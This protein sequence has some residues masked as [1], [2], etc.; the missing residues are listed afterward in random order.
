M[1]RGYVEMR[2]TYDR[3]QKYVGTGICLY[4]KQWKDGRVVNCVDAPQLNE[5]LDSMLTKVRQV[6]LDMMNDG[7]IDIS[8]IQDRLNRTDERMDFIG[9]CEQ[10]AE[11]K[12]Y[13]KA[14]DSQERYDRFLRFFRQWGG[15]VRFEDITESKIIAY[16]R[17]LA[18]RG[19][20]AYSKWNNYHRFLNTFIIDAIESGLLQRNPYK[21]LNIE[22]GYKAGIE[23]YLAPDEFRRLKRA[24]MPTESLERVRDL[25]L[26][27]SYTCMSYSDMKDFDCGMIQEIRGMRVYVGYRRKTSKQF[28]IPLLPPAL[29]ILKKYGGK[30]PMISNVKYNLQLKVVAQCIG[31][32]K[33]L[34]THWARHTGATL[35]LNSGVDMRVVSRICGHSSTRITE[36]VYAKLLNE[37]IVDAVSKVRI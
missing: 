6:I 22:K 2:I 34:S 7:Y 17:Y 23:K 24:K 21:W 12:K 16:D 18:K 28:S 27:Q 10:R 20:K 31:V 1:G 25:F 8:S 35:L 36:Q 14:K 26:F 32:D 19:L 9:F 5:T 3:K 30:L 13:G 29:D 11:I 37:T 15:I 4:P 33:P